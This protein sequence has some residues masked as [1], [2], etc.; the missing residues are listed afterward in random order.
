[1]SDY[2][3]SASQLLQALGA[4]DTPEMRN[5][6]EAWFRSEGGPASNPLNVYNSYNQMQTGGSVNLGDNPLGATASYIR[7]RMPGIHQA[8]LA[9]NPN[10][11]LQAVANSN[12][13]GSNYAAPY[14]G[15]R[16]Y[17]QLKAARTDIPHS[18]YRH[19]GALYLQG[20]YRSVS[21]RN[22]YAMQPPAT[23][24]ATTVMQAAAEV[25]KPAV[26]ITPVLTPRER[27]TRR[28]TE[29]VKTNQR[30][31]ANIVQAAKKPNIGAVQRKEMLTMQTVPY[32]KKISTYTARA[33][34]LAKVKPPNVAKT[35]HVAS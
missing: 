22:R 30:Y 2:Q 4:P 7:R 16:T 21:G 19:Y 8:A 32:K 18:M 14:F 15:L 12:W 33:K 10:K 31:L 34:T 27:Q 23:S 13:E 17:Q 1:M 5:A 24:G 25:V 29:A 20:I 11:F 26:V 6:V 28:Y 35:K 9:G 3:T